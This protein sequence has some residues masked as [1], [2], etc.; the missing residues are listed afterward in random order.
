MEIPFIWISLLKIILN[1]IWKKVCIKAIDVYD[2]LFIVEPTKDILTISMM[3]D[4]GIHFFCVYRG[5]NKE[6]KIPD[7]EITYLLYGET[8]KKKTKKKKKNIELIWFIWSDIIDLIKRCYC[9]ILMIHGKSGTGKTRLIEET[10]SI[11]K[12]KNFSTKYFYNNNFIFSFLLKQWYISSIYNL[13]S[14]AKYLT[15][16]KFW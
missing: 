2:D 8:K 7:Y 3:S 11:S 12:Q 5:V 9:Q 10:I 6:Q 13:L 4:Y 1:I 15:Y 14:E 16:L